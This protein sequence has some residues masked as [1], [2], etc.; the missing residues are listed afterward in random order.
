MLEKLRR[1][2][3]LQGLGVKNVRVLRH[4]ET[5]GVLDFVPEQAVNVWSAS[6]TFTAMAAGIAIGEGFFGLDDPVNRFISHMG[7]CDITV[8]NLLRMTTGHAKCPLSRAIDAHEVPDDLLALFVN[9]PRVV[10]PGTKFIYDN[11]A[12]YVIS[13]LIEHVTGQMLDV[14]LYERALKQIGFARPVWDVCPRGHTQGF[15]GLHLSVSQL[16]RF[17]QLLLQGGEW[18]GK[19]LIPRAFV[20]ASMRPQISTVDF[21]APFATADSRAGYGYGLW[22]NSYP[23]SCRMDGMYGQYVVLLP[24]KDAV[25][26]YVSHEPSRMLDILA[27]TW[28]H[29]V[30]EMM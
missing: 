6:K 12:W 30:N 24:S 28:T 4:G 22:M 17:G 21:D 11:L 16:A 26:S 29:V 25:V 3:E 7:T 14:F 9:E 15:A 2:I 23:G 18:E 10:R 20:T 27:L 5:I 8:R 19:Q 13:R 1:K